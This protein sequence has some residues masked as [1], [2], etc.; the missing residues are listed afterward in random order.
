MNHHLIVKNL[1]GQRNGIVIFNELSFALHASQVAIVK[2]PNGSGKTSLL[3][4]IAGLIPLEHGG[5]ISLNSSRVG[6]REYL[7]QIN[8]Y[9]HNLFWP[10]QIAAY[11][12]YK[13]W[14]EIFCHDRV[15]DEPPIFPLHNPL[16]GSLAQKY[17]SEGQQRL[18]HLMSFSF[19]RPLWLLDEPLAA[20]DRAHQKLVIEELEKFRHQGGM[21]II[22]SH[23]DIPLKADIELEFK[24]SIW[25]SNYFDVV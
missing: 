13:F 17:L 12:N 25:Q 19:Q 4:F 20:L 8:Y 16:L 2:G 18:L 11:D 22:T 1:I 24:E 6:S 21:I 9:G 15:S 5:D 7:T 23:Q 3:R 10:K 14:K